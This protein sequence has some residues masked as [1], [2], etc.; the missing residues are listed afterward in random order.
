M[1]EKVSAFPWPRHLGDKPSIRPLGTIFSTRTISPGD[2]S[3]V[4][5]REGQGYSLPGPSRN[6]FPSV[7]RFFSLIIVARASWMDHAGSLGFQ[8]DLSHTLPHVCC[9][10]H[11][12]QEHG[13][14]QE[15][16]LP[17]WYKS[18]SSHFYDW[19]PE[20]FKWLIVLVFYSRHETNIVL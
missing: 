4:Q 9:A 3:T 14:P 5:N 16:V 18:C 10:P 1:L 6:Q 19:T 20:L 8:Q 12:L 13:V 17:E 7:P 15:D 2:S 11:V